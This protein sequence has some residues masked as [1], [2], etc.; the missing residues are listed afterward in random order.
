VIVND[1]DLGGRPAQIHP[2]VGQAIGTARIVGNR[3]VAWADGGQLH[4][5]DVAFSITAWQAMGGQSA[6]SLGANRL[7]RRQLK[8]LVLNPFLQP[9]YIQWAQTSEG[10]PSYT[11]RADADDGWYL[12]SNLDWDAESYNG[13]G[14]IDAA[15]TVAQVAPSLPS[16][17]AVWWSGAALARTF[18][19]G[20]Q[21]LIALPVGSGGNNGPLRPGAEGNVPIW[22]LPL[23]AILDPVPFQRPGTIGGLYTGGCR[24]LDSVSGANT[25]PLSGTF[26]NSN[27]VE[28]KGVQHDFMGDVIVTNGLLLLRFV[29]G[30]Q[31]SPAVYFW[32]TSLATPA[33]QLYG[34]VFYVDTGFGGGNVREINLDQVGLQEARIRLLVQTTSSPSQFAQLSWRMVAGGYHVYC[35]LKPLTQTVV[36]ALPIYFSLSN[37]QKM[38][39]S[40]AGA[41][42]AVVSPSTGVAPATTSGFGAFFGTTLNDPLGGYL[43]KDTPTN[44]PFVTASANQIGLGDNVA[45]N[46]TK[47]FGIFVV[48]V[49]R[50]DAAWAEA[51]GGTLGTG[52]SSV[53]DAAAS[54]GNAA[55]CASG[56]VAGNADRWGTLAN[57]LVAGG[58]N[59][60]WIVDAWVWARVTSAT[61]VL[62]EMQIGVWDDTAGSYVASTTYRPV[63]F[64]TTYT[65]KKVAVNVGST[66]TAGHNYQLR[67]VTVAT[68]GTD[69]FFDKGFLGVKSGG[70]VGWGGPV[71]IDGQFAFD[72]YTEWVM[73]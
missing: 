25:V 50:L 26:L 27:W 67:A 60:F 40:D 65:P 49:Q 54:G 56:T 41:V 55:K 61:G 43:Y 7:L 11:S 14:S 38:V 1:L 22:I 28:V 52:W 36:T 18:S 39:Y 20:T 12:V 71:D 69:W 2:R 23:P 35:E 33:W 63:D 6:Y 46:A 59:Q 58:V 70:P 51:E 44:Q 37:N 31:H 9:C 5:L 32:N 47:R 45:Q 72:R 17:L 57:F 34:D 10:N 15:M 48:P 42:D 3:T 13:A 73:G 62:S 64:A 21:P 68:I 66:W 53:P 24:V 19:A 8:E 4:G 29:Q 16:S 30:T